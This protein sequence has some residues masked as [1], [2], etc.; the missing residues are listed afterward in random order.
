[1]EDLRAL[2]VNLTV[3]VQESELPLAFRKRCK[4]TYCSGAAHLQEIFKRSAKTF[5][6]ICFDYDYPNRNG[7]QLIRNTKLTRPSLPIVMLTVQHSEA[8]AV[9]AF[10][11]KVFDYLV[12]P[13]ASSDAERCLTTLSDICDHKEAQPIREV[14]S[15]LDKIPQEVLCTPIPDDCSLASALDY[16]ERNFRSPIKGKDVAASSGLDQFRFSRL[17][18]ETF[19]LTFRDYLINYRLREACRLLENPQSA[20][21]DVGFAVGFQDPGY[22]SRIFKQRLGI[23]PSSLIGSKPSAAINQVFDVLPKIAAQ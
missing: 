18:R 5:D 20:V 4:V 12:K 8:L 1:M 13:V 19:G 16:I 9:W 23:T 10:R 3:G 11:T 7:L 21:G 15:T 6:L 17:F 2:W 14:F 22:F